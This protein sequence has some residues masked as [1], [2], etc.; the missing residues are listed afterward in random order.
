MGSETENFFRF[1][2]LISELVADVLRYRLKQSYI[3]SNFQTF[4]KDNDVLHT[5]F[6]L[7][8]PIYSCC[9]KGCRTHASRVLSKK[10][11]DILYDSDPVRCCKP[12]QRDPNETCMCCVTPK[13]VDESDLDIS[14]LSLILINCCNL[15]P[16]EKEAIQKIREMKNNYISHNPHCS[17]S[18]VDFESLLNILRHSIKHLDSTNIYLSRYEN[19]L[20]RTLDETLMKQYFT[21]CAESTKTEHLETMETEVRFVPFRL[22]VLNI[23]HCFS[24]FSII[25]VLTYIQL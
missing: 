10:Q 7:F 3:N 16:N 20:N 23:L 15:M 13:S 8:F 22:N 25:K 24:A 6:H 11:W 4:L 18:N 1:I 12:K 2:C 17:L 19:I 14:L 5:I 9:W 21:Y